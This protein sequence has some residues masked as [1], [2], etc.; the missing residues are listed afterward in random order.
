MSHSSQA[1]PSEAP[2][3]EAPSPKPR[4]LSPRRRV[5]TGI[6][7]VAILTLGLFGASTLFDSSNT[8]SALRGHPE[9]LRPGCTWDSSGYFVQNCKVWSESQQRHVIVQIRAS[10]GSDSGVYLLDGMRASE[11]RSAWTTDVQAARVYDAKADTTLVM[12]VGGASSFYTDWD[13][14]AGS[15]NTIIKQET[16]LTSELPAYLEEQFGVARNNNAIVGLSMSGGPAV[17]LAERHPEQFKVVQA[18]SGYY[19]TDNPIGALGVFATQSLVSNY[20]SGIVNMWG[21]P[22]GTRWTDNDPSKNVGKL[23]ENGQVLVISSGNGF[24]TPSELAK[25]APQDQISAIAL[26]I[27]SAVST[28]LM[29]LQAKQSGASVISL[30]NYGGHTWENWGRA[31]GDGKGHVLEALRNN[32]PVTAKTTV[33][34]ASGSPDPEAPAKV[35]M[36]VKQAA[37]AS[38]A[39]DATVLAALE[40]TDAS[41]PS[42][43]TSSS[44]SAGPSDA[45]ESAA[46]SSDDVSASAPAAPESAAAESAAPAEQSAATTTDPSAPEPAPSAPPVSEQPAS[47]TTTTAPV[48]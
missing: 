34:S 41:S 32:P 14:G 30:P 20:V 44:E 12:P 15:N 39:L 4:R 28:V 17:T 25:L 6:S 35:T 16:F 43:E 22:G 47:S 36:A 7:V 10:S 46:P 42:S 13:G 24:L 40:S 5:L 37:A 27:L 1:S 3:S 48:R 29:Q 9:K 2:G 19:Q 26:E 8:A 31:L 21:K 38:P 18:M 11:T 33:V 23:A 45:S